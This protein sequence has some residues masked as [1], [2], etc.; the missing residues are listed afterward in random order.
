M[1]EKSKLFLLDEGTI[2]KSIASYL[3]VTNYLQVSKIS[4]FEGPITNDVPHESVELGEVYERIINGSNGVKETC[5]RIRGES[6]VSVKK[7]LKGGLSYYT[8]AGEFS[9]RRNDSIITLSG[10]TVF[11]FDKVGNEED[12]RRLMDKLKRDKYFYPLLVFM[13]PS[14]DGLKFVTDIRDVMAQVA[15]WHSGTEEVT[16]VTYKEAYEI[17]GRYIGETYGVKVDNTS[18]WSRACF[19]S[20]DPRAY[21][22][23]FMVGGEA[24]EFCFE[25]EKFDASQWRGKKVESKRI[26]CSNNDLKEI[27]FNAKL[28]RAVE[29]CAD[30]LEMHEIE[31]LDEY[32]DWC[33]RAGLQIAGNFGEKGRKVFRRL[34]R[35][36][37]KF[38]TT[39][40]EI[41]YDNLLRSTNGTGSIDTF[42]DLFE[43]TT[44]VSIDELRLTD[45]VRYVYPRL[46]KY[47]QFVMDL[48]EDD[49]EKLM[50]LICTITGFGPLLRNVDIS[51]KGLRYK[52]NMYTLLLGSSGSDKSKMTK[53]EYL[54]EKIDEAY[55]AE[56]ERKSLLYESRKEKNPD[57][58]EQAPT[59]QSYMIPGN[60]TAAALSDYLAA[61]RGCGFIF[62]TEAK[63]LL[64]N[65]ESSKNG[66]D[67]SCI[68]EIMLKGFGNEKVGPLRKTTL[69]KKVKRPNLSVCISCPPKTEEF[70]RLMK[71]ITSGLMSRFWILPY[72]TK[73]TTTPFSLDGKDFL[74]TKEME[75]LQNGLLNLDK[76]LS[77][78]G[79]KTLLVEWGDEHRDKMVNFYNENYCKEA[80]SDELKGFVFRNGFNAH[81]L[82]AIF[83][84]LKCWEGPSTRELL[85]TVDTISI[86]DDDFEVAMK[87]AEF[88]LDSTLSVVYENS[89][90]TSNDD[91][92][93]LLSYLPVGKQMKTNEIVV[94]GK[95]LN[96]SERTV[97]RRLTEY[98]RDGLL[99]HK[100]GLYMKPSA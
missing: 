45:V 68:K 47:L 85:K 20:Y 42:F 48:G 60:A 55:S 88:M 9:K 50:L 25:R 23:P 36:S 6:D 58:L 79:D 3:N 100:Y 30:Y 81:R 46:P 4:A 13:S 74:N 84:I 37:Q 2:K 18:D 66:S 39:Q 71:Q 72:K 44:N 89:N 63:G 97:K 73:F 34:S 92:V 99:E 96:M 67:F 64:T 52:L 5:E 40:F 7:K 65:L 31:F 82:M 51:H 91:D 56:W 32:D 24:D 10:C 94:L 80:N 43:E 83:A 86:D 90:L 62:D 61:N 29:L 76:L 98:S 28:L 57:S 21:I 33:N 35:L 49:K 27:K 70:R 22:Y 12:I 38:D 75:R 69:A 41:D 87:I 54:F 1:V 11:D 53:V 95:A 59:M 8:F 15:Q 19:A 93:D 77:E 78:R 26:Q 14:G 16:D 17:I